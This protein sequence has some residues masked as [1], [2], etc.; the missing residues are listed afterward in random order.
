MRGLA[1]LIVS[2]VLWVQLLHPMLHLW[3]HSHASSGHYSECSLCQN[4]ALTTP[5][6][7]LTEQS[8]TP[9]PL[10]EQIAHEPLSASG[11]SANERAP[12]LLS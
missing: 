12:P 8:G 6:V 7:Q 4:A 3:D 1:G 9:A 2:C 11:I 5:F 10:D